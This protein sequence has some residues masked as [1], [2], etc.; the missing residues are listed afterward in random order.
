LS[1]PFPWSR[2]TLGA[3]KTIFNLVPCHNEFEKEFAQFL[4]KAS[5]AGK[6]WAYLKVLQT[7]Y[8]QQPT[9]FEDLF[10]LEQKR[11]I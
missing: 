8:K 2:T 11:I 4:Q 10:V 5:D 7:A 6:P 9:R 3:D 1:R